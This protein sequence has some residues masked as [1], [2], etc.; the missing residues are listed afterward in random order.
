MDT[1]KVSFG[2]LIAFIDIIDTSSIKNTAKHQRLLPE[3]YFARMLLSYHPD[4]L[5]YAKVLC[6]WMIRI[7]FTYFNK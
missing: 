7:Y 3:A 1:Q 5:V 2:I 6:L 4:N